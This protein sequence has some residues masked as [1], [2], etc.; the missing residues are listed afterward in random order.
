MERLIWRPRWA[1]AGRTFAQIE[2]CSRRSKATE[3][4]TCTTPVFKSNAMPRDSCFFQI[5]HAGMRAI[6]KR[7]RDPLKELD[8]N[9]NTL[10]T[11]LQDTR[12]SKIPANLPRQAEALGL[13]PRR[14]HMSGCFLDADTLE[15]SCMTRATCW[16]FNLGS[17]TRL[18]TAD[19]DAA[20]GESSVFALLSLFRT[21][22]PGRASQHAQSN[23]NLPHDM[24]RRSWSFLIWS[25]RRAL[26]SIGYLS[27][28]CAIDPPPPAS[29]QRA[30]HGPIDGSTLTDC[31]IDTHL[32]LFG[33]DLV[34]KERRREVFPLTVIVLLA[35]PRVAVE[36]RVALPQTGPGPQPE[37]H[38]VA[39]PAHLL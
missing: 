35:P 9:E 22:E 32:S 2:F 11:P 37:L 12:Y 20:K 27:A 33:K 34:S 23:L 19:R 38:V 29:N 31:R 14:S 10:M 24:E 30:L 15:C 3:P 17:D 18:P 25:S 26:T 1:R 8:A 6:K 21:C 39:G 5:T 16:L 4:P 7:S 36:R 28:S 13:E